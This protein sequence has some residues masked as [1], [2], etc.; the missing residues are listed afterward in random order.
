M[1]SIS[2]VGNLQIT[3]DDG[4]FLDTLLMIVDTQNLAHMEAKCSD[5]KDLI[6]IQWKRG[7]TYS[8]NLQETLQIA[9]LMTLP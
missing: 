4:E 7:L 1:S 3:E 8:L 6:L 9:S 2:P 5:M